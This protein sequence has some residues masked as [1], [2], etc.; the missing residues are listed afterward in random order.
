V[1]PL[2]HRAGPGK[3]VVA[4]EPRHQRGGRGEFR[5][6][7]GVRTQLSEAHG[8]FE[9]SHLRRHADAG[10]CRRQIRPETEGRVHAVIVE[11][12]PSADQRIRRER[13]V[14][15]LQRRNPRQCAERVGDPP[16]IALPGQLGARAEHL[17]DPAAQFLL[18]LLR[19]CR[20]G[21][22]RSALRHHRGRLH[23]RCPIRGGPGERR[24]GGERAEQRERGVGG[25]RHVALHGC[26]GE[27]TYR[28]GSRI[29]EFGTGA[30]TGGTARRSMRATDT[31]FA[32]KA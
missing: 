22:G 19:L 2:P 31:T 10:R 1:Q 7:D 6:D 18:R 21:P 23:A 28:A 15:A 17:F 13:D 5:I 32:R 29:A 14:A 27:R 3:D 30:S 11:H 25:G 26:A 24:R 9:R 8:D 16:V 4:F 12:P 20:R